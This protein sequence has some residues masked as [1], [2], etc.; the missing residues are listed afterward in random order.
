MLTGVHFLL[1]YACTFECDHCFL[2]CSP[3][4]E[5]TFT[6]EQIRAALAQI[7]EVDGIRTVYFEGGEP[8]LLHPL[9]VEAVRLAREKGFEVGVVT[10]AYWATGEEDARLWLSR[11][12]ELG[13]SDLG[14]SDD[15]Y[16]GAAER[17]KVALACA[18]SLGIPSG[19]ICIEEPSPLEES[20]E[21]GKPVL[22]GGVMLRGRAAETLLDG[23][24]RHPASRFDE[25]PHEELRRP[26][27]VHIDP[28]GNVHLC[29]GVVLGNV[30]EKPLKALLEE[31][32]PESHPIS[33]PLLR[34]GPAALAREHGVPLDEAGYADACH[35]CYS[36]RKALLDRFPAALAPPQVYG[37][38]PVAPI[39]TP[40][41][42]RNMKGRD[43]AS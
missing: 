30:W 5:G 16:H 40:T 4:A 23:L 21:K 20:A 43:S 32:E 11:L 2:F 38:E 39:E 7:E 31:Y 35:L 10:N 22:G 41:H 17:A 1:T 26:E 18:G 14:V 29:Q 28:Q 19:S 24:P 13:V 12:A 27:R 8:F 33:G 34:G 6:L 9:L 25:C 15:D 36:V 3:R 37:V 42:S